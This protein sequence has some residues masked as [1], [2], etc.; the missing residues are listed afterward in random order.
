MRCNG[1]SSTESD[2][3]KAG[4]GLQE[5]P[6]SEPYQPDPFN[7]PFLQV[8]DE[9]QEYIIYVQRVIDPRF[10]LLS[11]EQFTDLLIELKRQV[12][13]FLGFQIKIVEKKAPMEFMDFYMSSLSILQKKTNQ[14]AIEALSLE[15]DDTRGMQKI[16]HL[17][18]YQVYNRPLHVINMYRP[19][20]FPMTYND[21]DEATAILTEN[22]IARQRELHQVKLPDGSSLLDDRS[23]K[24]LDYV[25]WMVLAHD[26]PDVHL[27]IFNGMLSGEDRNMSLNAII[28]GGMRE[29]FVEDNYHNE[30]QGICVMGLY[31]FLGKNEFFS[32]YR[33][34]IPDEHLINIISLVLTHGMGKL[35]GRYQNS[36]LHP[37]CIFSP[38]LDMAYYSWYLRI[39]QEECVT[40]PSIIKRDF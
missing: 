18:Q 29:I 1:T 35:L 9:K 22:Y 16:Q 37:E 11:E 23:S 38:P 30:L 3:S 13:H 7:L 26:L 14:K 19:L 39:L 20:S 2:S 36:S 6:T 40:E 28:T 24:S 4:L 27:I 8:L 34:I 12:F 33:E 10:P 5:Q 21:H 31:S 25:K 17:I 15:D 32:K